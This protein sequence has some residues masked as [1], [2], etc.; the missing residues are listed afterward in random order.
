M[1]NELDRSKTLYLYPKE[2]A[3]PH[4]DL[5]YPWLA[6]SFVLEGKTYSVVYLN[7]PENPKE[8]KYSAYRDYARFGAF[9]KTTIEKDQELTIQVRFLMLE[10]ALPPA[11]WIQKQYNLYTGREL[12]TPATTERGPS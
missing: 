4:Q 2:D 8:T 7:H 12:P 5:D 10:S 1:A 9:F 6:C 3:K 11:D